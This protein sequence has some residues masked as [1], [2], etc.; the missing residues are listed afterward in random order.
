MKQQEETTTV[1]EKI[2]SVL[3]LRDKW[4]Y[5]PQTDDHIG[6][7]LGHGEICID[8]EKM[9]D[10]LPPSIEDR[11]S[12]KFEK[13]VMKIIS[14]NSNMELFEEKSFD[15]YQADLKT[16]MDLVSFGPAKTM[17]YRRLKILQSRFI[18]H[19]WLNDSVEVLEV[20][21]IPHRDFYNV[22]K[23]DNHVHHS[24]CMNQVRY[25]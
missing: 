18:L 1:C 10:K 5:K 3:K 17:C 14:K 12:L 21:S 16:V 19:Q 8:V 22:R 25:N 4:V 20:K 23:I 11:Y 13:G 9:K 15:E 7:N 6:A 2:Q 24:A